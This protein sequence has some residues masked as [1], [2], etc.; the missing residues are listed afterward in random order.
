[1]T[2]KELI[3]ALKYVEN[4][5]VIMCGDVETFR[6]YDIEMLQTTRTMEVAY[7]RI[8]EKKHGQS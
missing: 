3:D 4:D 1:M 7:L 8:K 5:V 6:T 2:K